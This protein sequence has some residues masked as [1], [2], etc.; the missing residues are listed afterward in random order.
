MRSFL[1]TGLMFFIATTASAIEIEDHNNLMDHGGGHLM[2]MG[3]GMVM[4]QNAD[5][6]P[7]GCGSYRTTLR[8]LPSGGCEQIFRLPTR[9]GDYLGFFGPP[10]RP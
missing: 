4:G 9:E 8:K 2:D 5:R 1:L 10:R 3:G 6:I 7:D